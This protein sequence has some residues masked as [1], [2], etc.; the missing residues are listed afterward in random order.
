MVLNLKAV[1][2]TLGALLFFLGIALLTPMAVGLI[3]G[4]ASW[5]SFGLTALHRFTL[6]GRDMFKAERL[7]PGVE[8]PCQARGKPQAYKRFVAVAHGSLPRSVGTMRVKRCRLQAM[9][10]LQNNM[11]HR[12]VYLVLF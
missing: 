12:H 6:F 11:K 8:A 10:P 9:K 1:I 5:W 7:W 3:Y 2:T 4:E